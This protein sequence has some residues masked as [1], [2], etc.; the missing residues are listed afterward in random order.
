MYVYVN[1]LYP[2]IELQES[3]H[4]RLPFNVHLQF[5]LKY[6]ILYAWRLLLLDKQLIC[7]PFHQVIPV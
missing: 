5:I 4:K 2:Q 1:F 6:P 3:S 7:H